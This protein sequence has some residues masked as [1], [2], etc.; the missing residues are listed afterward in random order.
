MKRVIAIATLVLI[1]PH[2]HAFEWRA[3][4]WRVGVAYVS[5]L[6]DVTDLYEQNLRIEGLNADVD[7]K[8]PLGLTAGVTYD[9]PSG[10]RLDVTLGPAFFIGGEVSYS[11]VPLAATLGY[12]FDMGGDASPFV[13]AGITHH[14]ASGDYEAGS[15]PG[16]LVAA[17]LD[18]R[19]LTIEVAFDRSEV[20]FDTAVCNANN[21]VCTPAREK[22]NT[23]EV[24]ASVFWRFR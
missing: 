20:E 4:E 23:Y 11:E 7:L 18:F 15:N 8:V 16:L 1:A 10:L 3:F 12:N 17:G 9:Y 2:A 6:S 21:T 13:R 22:L 14:F 19:R 5:G 24:I